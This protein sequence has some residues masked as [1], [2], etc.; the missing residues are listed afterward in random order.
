[1]LRWCGG[2][3]YISVEK[4]D[5]MCG[6]GKFTVGSWGV[7]VS[8]AGSPEGHHCWEEG[9]MLLRMVGKESVGEGA[10]V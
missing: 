8:I 2:D 7:V 5:C 4:D 3:G 6:V 1:L 9:T 10:V